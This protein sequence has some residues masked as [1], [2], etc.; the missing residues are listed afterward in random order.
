MPFEQ[1]LALLIYASYP[2]IYIPTPEEER[3]EQLIAS[4]AQTGS[5]E[6]ALRYWDFAAGFTDGGA[7]RNNP[8]QALQEIEK[9]RADS[10][11]VFVLRDFHR[12]LDDPHVARLLRN[13]SR[14]LRNS[15]KT[16]IILAPTLRIP[17]DLAEEITVL[18]L[19]PP[20]ADE[21]NQEL[22]QALLKVSVT[23][24]DAGRDA[25]VKA[26]Q[27]LIMSRI[28]LALARAV[29]SYGRLDERA[30]P[31]MLEE[32][33]QRIRQ[34]QV[35]EFWP[36]N[37]TLDDIGGL[38]ILKRWLEQRAAAFTPE[39]RAY[40]LPNP[41]GILL[42]GIQG[43]GKSISAKATA[44][45]WQLPLLRLDIGRLMGGLVGESEARTREMIRI[46]EAMAPC[47]LF[48]DELDKGFAG[49]GSGFVGDSGTSARVFGTILTWM[50]EKTAPVFIAATANSIESLPPEILRKGRFD[51]VF[52]LDL[53]SEQERQEIFEVH[54]NRVR[55][56]RVRNFNLKQLAIQSE[57]F[58]GAEIEQ[59]IYESMHYA[60]DQRREFDADD[61]MRTMSAIVPLS[62]TAGE[63][64]RTLHAWAA[65]GR[66]RPASSD[67]ARSGMMGQL[68]GNASLPG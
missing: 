40:G 54:L 53:P 2:I 60:F 64:I 65:S 19:L 10:P 52:F 33:R 66:C 37:E 13:L 17:L 47:V 62:K 34:T 35:L 1:E 5:P 30:I 27:G 68:F 42:V 32:K 55:P 46:A 14:H 9:A 45:L 8:T 24:T 15:R 63:R 4:V 20:V 43:T 26:A 44:S 57:G 3:A 39:A 67:A 36:T 16:I 18:D 7:G 11:A 48:L 49:I 61:I 38:D 59:A 28:R 41:K 50:E 31:M 12:Y 29:S 21:I 22:D 6:R 56:D 25:L 51:E 23:L 58:N